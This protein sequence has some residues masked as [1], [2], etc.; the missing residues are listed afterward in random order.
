MNALGNWAE[1]HGGYPPREALLPG[2]AFWKCRG[3]PH[4]TNAVTGGPMVLGSGDGNFD[5]T[6]DGKWRY[7]VEGHLNGGGETTQSG[8]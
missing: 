4:L 2:D 6:T 8:G 5:Y 7:S 3:A 1:R